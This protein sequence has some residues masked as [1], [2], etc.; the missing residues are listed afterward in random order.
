MRVSLCACESVC[1]CE[2]AC[3]CESVCACKSVCLCVC[4][5]VRECVRACVR[6]YTPRN[7]QL[8]E[9]LITICNRGMTDQP[10]GG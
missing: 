6:P 7:C 4:V 1:A 9:A 10:E 5:C 8:F 3:A 2:S